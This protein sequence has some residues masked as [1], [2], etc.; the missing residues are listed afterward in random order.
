[1]RSCSPFMQGAIS[2]SA[3][4]VFVSVSHG[5]PSAQVNTRTICYS[6]PCQQHHTLIV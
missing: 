6:D 3:I 4:T 1:M 5:W 2:L